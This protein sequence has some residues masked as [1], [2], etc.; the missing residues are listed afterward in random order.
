MPVRAAA[1]TRLPRI[2]RLKDGLL[3]LPSNTVEIAFYRESASSTTATPL[4]YGHGNGATLQ[5]CRNIEVSMKLL[6]HTVQ[7]HVILAARSR[8][9]PTAIPWISKGYQLPEAKKLPEPSRVPFS[10]H[11][12]NALPHKKAIRA[13]NQQSEKQKTI[14][15][16]THTCVH[17]S[18]AT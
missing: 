17:A 9:G 14:H 15:R 3:I 16:P 5:S 4:L 11:R 7:I 1:H 18:P 2:G 8:R 13:Y 10:K 6:S 12:E